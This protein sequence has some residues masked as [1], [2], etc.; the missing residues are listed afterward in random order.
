[1]VVDNLDGYHAGSLG[2]G[3]TVFTAIGGRC[4]SHRG[5]N[6]MGRGGILFAERVLGGFPGSRGVEVSWSLLPRLSCANFR[7]SFPINGQSI[8]KWDVSKQR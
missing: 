6:P 5:G 1:M 4:G 3:K 7:A 8:M 2:G